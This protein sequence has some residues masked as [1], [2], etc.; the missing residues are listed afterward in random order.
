MNGRNVEY[1]GDVA[2]RGT[3]ADKRGIP[4]RA[5]RE[6]K[7]V[8]QNGFAGPGLAREHGEAGSELDAQPVN[9]DD[10]TNGQSDKHGRLAISP[11]WCRKRG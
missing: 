2:L 5:E 4:P 11:C 7:R 1:G 9:D 10:V 8:K 6:G 3:L